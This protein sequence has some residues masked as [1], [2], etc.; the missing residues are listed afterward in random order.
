[1][2]KHK[3]FCIF[4]HSIKIHYDNARESLID[5]LG[6]SAA[7]GITIEVP[8]LAAYEVYQAVEAWKECAQEYCAG[9]EAEKK[10]NK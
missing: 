2:F 5:A 8:P 6:H 3:N 7:A 10:D 4:F 9:M 1:M